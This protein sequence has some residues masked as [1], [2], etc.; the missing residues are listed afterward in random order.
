MTEVT[1]SRCG[2]TRAGLERPPFPG[3]LGERV[4]QHVCAACWR[5]WLGMQVKFINEYRLSPLDPQHFEFLTTQMR[6][7]VNLPDEGEATG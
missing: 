1:C 5:E 3:P 7:F 4:R 6:T 2:D